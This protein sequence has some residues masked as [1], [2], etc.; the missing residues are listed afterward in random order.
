[1]VVRLEANVPLQLELQQ[2]QAA[3]ICIHDIVVLDAISN[4]TDS[5]RSQRTEK[6]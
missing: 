1:L 4:L 6:I 5:K 3:P 2:E